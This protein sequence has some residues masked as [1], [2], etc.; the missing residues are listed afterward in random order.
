M[1][2]SDFTL[3]VKPEVGGA[4]RLLDRASGTGYRH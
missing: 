4:P 2:Y 3:Y 1:K